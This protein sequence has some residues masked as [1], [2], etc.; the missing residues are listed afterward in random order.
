LSKHPNITSAA[1]AA[2]VSRRMVYYAAEVDEEFKAAWDDTLEGALDALEETA[3]KRAHEGSDVLTIFMLKAGRPQ[4][5]RD[6]VSR[7][8]FTDPTGEKDYGAHLTTSDI[9]REIM[10]IVDAARARAAGDADAGTEAQVGGPREA[11]ADSASG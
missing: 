7:V 10:A 5:Y 6:P 3:Y 8:S 2:G 11:E 4:K 1:K 9:D